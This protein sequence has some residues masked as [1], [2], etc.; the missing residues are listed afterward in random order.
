MPNAATQDDAHGLAS[1]RHCLHDAEKVRGSNIETVAEFVA[2]FIK[3]CL[4]GR[5]LF[6]NKYATFPNEELCAKSS[7]SCRDKPADLAAHIDETNRRIPQ[8]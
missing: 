5:V 2:Q 6:H 8:R 1:E 7:M 4:A 3:L